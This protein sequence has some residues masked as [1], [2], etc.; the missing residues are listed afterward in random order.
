MWELDHKEGRMLK[1]WCFWTVVLEKTLESPLDC[2]EIKLV[3]PKRNQ[4]WIFIGRTVAAAEASILWSPDAKSWFIGKDSNA[5]KDWRQKEKGMAENERDSITDSMDLNLSKLREIAEDRG[6]WCAAIHGVVKNQTRSSNWTTTNAAL[7]PNYFINKFPP[8][9]FYLYYFLHLW[10][11]FLL[12]FLSIHLS[13]PHSNGISSMKPCLLPATVNVSLF[14]T[15]YLLCWDNF[16][17]LS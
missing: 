13:W 3:N 2:K 14:C 17:I 1:N 9:C 6:A 4:P 11:P 7:M 10:F 16:H 12:I 8:L 5:E 15:L